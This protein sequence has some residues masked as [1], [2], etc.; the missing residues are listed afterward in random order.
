MGNLINNR[1]IKDGSTLKPKSG[2]SVVLTSTLSSNHLVLDEITTP[3][4]TSDKGKIY[5]KNT[6]VLYFQDGAGIEHPIGG[7][8]YGEFKIADNATATVIRATNEWQAI[9]ANAVTGL[10]SGFSYDAGLLGE[11]ASVADAGGGSIL[12]TD[13]GHG[14]TIGNII[15]INGNTDA[16]YNGVF[17]VLTTPTDDTFTV[18][19]TYTAT[20]TGYWQ[21]GAALTVLAGGAGIYKGTWASCGISATNSHVFDFS[22]FVNTTQATAATARRKFSNADYGSF[23]GTEL[24]TF[25]EGDIIS[26]MA[27]D[28]TGNSDITI[29]S[30]DL[31]LHKM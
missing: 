7:T 10:V 16:A 24:V 20:D 12:I 15:S 13:T 18:T 4:A 21:K 27:R 8:S 28:I 2:E 29:R 3:T 30:L 25:A 22:P 19:A 17:E 9:T 23:S 1:W 11:I 5:T 14:L 6:N 26:F 31:N